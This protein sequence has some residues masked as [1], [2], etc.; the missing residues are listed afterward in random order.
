MFFF[1]EDGGSARESL[2]L[3]CRIVF[4]GRRIFFNANSTGTRLNIFLKTNDTFHAQFQPFIASYLYV[5][6]SPCYVEIV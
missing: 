2:F 6:R 5:L 4:F 3:T 1:P